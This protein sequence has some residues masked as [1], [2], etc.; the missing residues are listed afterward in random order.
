[1]TVLSLI[2]YTIK[3]FNNLLSKFLFPIKAL[4]NKLKLKQ[5]SQIKRIESGYLNRNLAN[6]LT[7]ILDLDNILVFPSLHKLNNYK[8]HIVINNRFYL[9]IRPHLEIF[10]N[11]LSENCEF[12]VYT[13]Y[14]KDY[15]D[16]IINF[17]DKN[18]R[19]SKR[20]YQ[21]DCIDKASDL[22]KDVKAKGFEESKVI[23]I[24]DNEVG[25]LTYKSKIN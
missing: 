6:K 3:T 24:D 17:I 1:M 22:Y 5:S 12:V 16:Q 11:D 19:I 15:A 9:Y 7:I 8:S 18:R 25:H 4:L 21:E 20:F 14:Q 2:S 13:T 23:I 10:L